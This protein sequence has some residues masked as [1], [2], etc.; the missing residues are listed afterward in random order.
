MVQILPPQPIRYLQKQVPFFLPSGY[1]VAE[2][3]GATAPSPMKGLFSGAKRQPRSITRRF[4]KKGAAPRDLWKIAG[5][6][7]QPIRYLQKQVPFFLPSGYGVAEGNGAKA[8]SP[9]KKLSTNCFFVHRL[10]VLSCG[11]GKFVKLLFC[12]VAVVQTCQSVTE[13]FSLISA[14]RIFRLCFWIV[15]RMLCVLKTS[16][17][18]GRF[19]DVNKQKL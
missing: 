7:T 19:S 5:L 2:G 11:C 6:R 14:L 15:L 17:N 9:M 13:N 3:N 16:A 4:E 10:F 1:G 18:G 12:R 8:P